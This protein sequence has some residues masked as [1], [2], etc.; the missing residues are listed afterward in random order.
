M[1]R[2]RVVRTGVEWFAKNIKCQDQCPAHTDVPRYLSLIKQGRFT[3]AYDVNRQANVLPAILGRVC[4]R[5]CEG[6]CRRRD[7][8]E[9]VS[10]CYLKRSAADYGRTTTEIAPVSRKSGPGVAIIGAGPTGLTAASDLARLGYRVDVFEALPVVG[11]MLRVGIPAYRLPREAVQETIIEDLRRLGVSIHLNSPAGKDITLDNLLERYDAVLIAAG[12][13][14]PE[15]LGIPGEY[16]QGVLHGVTF[17]RKVNLGE[18]TGLGE[19]VAVVGLGHT[20]IDCARSAKRLGARSVHVVYRRTSAEASVSADEIHEAE[21]EGITFGFLLT[22]LSVTSIDG[23]RVSGLACVRN[24]LGEPDERGRR[25]PVPLP[26]SE[27]EIQVDTV[28][29]AVSQ[30]PDNS[31]LPP[32]IGLA[33]SRWDR[34]EVDPKT[35]MSKRSGVFAAGDFITG[36]RDVISVIADAHSVSASID[37][38]ISGTDRRIRRAKFTVIEKYRRE[39][40]F[41][42]RERSPMP[43]LPAAGRGSL[44]E[45]VE[46]GY[47]PAT[48]MAQADRCLQ[49]QI[50][51]M[52]DGSRCILCGLCVDGCPMG[53]L[54]M[55][56]LKDIETTDADRQRLSKGVMK[57]GAAMVL[58]EKLCIRCGLCENRCP[59][60]AISM[61]QVAW[62]DVDTGADAADAAEATER[63]GHKAEARRS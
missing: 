50:N 61:V 47:D 7:L 49:C 23:F 10:I 11:G 55:V 25:R 15:K 51:V 1:S 17:M 26:G 5:L 41:A 35:F 45:E 21:E 59:T 20:A 60:K 43:T 40:D 44:E 39:G 2:F 62:E 37:K 32:E 3:E 52:I 34:L 6:A 24:E 29:P 4:V 57:G 12:A 30:S 46:L 36:P 22:P 33:M 9:T 8:D 16:L 14:K 56:A 38:Y 54:R 28:I 48:A 58:D 18:R 42:S 19:R 13:H 27:F 63:G 31:F 53:V